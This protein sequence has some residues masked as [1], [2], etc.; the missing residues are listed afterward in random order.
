MS[1]C[2]R[3][4]FIEKEQ[5]GVPARPHDWALSTFEFKKADDPPAALKPASDSLAI[6][7]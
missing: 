2:Q 5:F 7:M 1:G 4:R 6:V 3:S